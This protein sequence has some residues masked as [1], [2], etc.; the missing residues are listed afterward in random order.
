MDLHT[1]AMGVKG[2]SGPAM[3]VNPWLYFEYLATALQIKMRTAFGSRYQS[4]ITRNTFTQSNIVGLK[5]TTS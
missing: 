5:A 1:I 4:S 3:R 2:T